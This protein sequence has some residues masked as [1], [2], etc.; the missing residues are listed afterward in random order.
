MILVNNGVADLVAGYDR[1]LQANSELP[2][3]RHRLL[4]AY[5]QRRKVY[6][7]ARYAHRRQMTGL[8][9]ATLLISFGLVGLSFFLRCCF[10]GL[11][12]MALLT[13]FW[14]WRAV[15]GQPRPPAHPLQSGLLNSLLP[16]WREGLRGELPRELPYEGAPG[17]YNFVAHLQ[18]LPGNDSYI[19]YRLRQQPGDDIDVVVLGPQGVWV[20]EVKYWSGRIAWHDGQWEH[21]KAYYIA[22]PIDQ[23]PDQQWRRMADEVAETLRRHVPELMARWPALSEMQGGL[24][25]THPRATYDIARDCPVAWGDIHSWSRWL[26]MAPTIP[27]LDERCILQVLDALLD[28]H[29]QVSENQVTRSMYIYAKQLVEQAEARLR[30]WIEE[31]Q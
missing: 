1:I 14:L 21:S 31:T 29:R 19:I 17:E 11:A 3:W 28:R 30:A 12:G 2:H 5:A 22:A 8:I 4:E 25:F 6:D 15:L 10:M 24:V 18:A 7:A 26:V 13:V 23:P 16:R 9:P 20:F 27:G